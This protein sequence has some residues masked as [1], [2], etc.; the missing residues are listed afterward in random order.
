MKEKVKLK[1]AEIII[2]M[3]SKFA[4]E[5]P[6]DEYEKAESARRLN[7]FFYQGRKGADITINIE[8]VDRLSEAGRAEPVYNVY[9]FM[10]GKENWRLLKKG[11]G[12]VYISVIKEKRQLML[13]NKDF[14]RVSA[15]LLLKKD[16][17]RVWKVEDVVY[18]F[19]QVL[20]IAYLA[21]RGKGIFTHAVGIRDL[22]GKGLLFAGES[23]CGKSATARLW[24]NHTRAMV[25]NDDRVIVRRQ[26]GRFFIH[27][28][29]WHGAFSDYLGSRIES[30]PL[31]KLFFIYHA[32]KNRLERIR[33]EKTFNYLYP[34]T[35]PVFW[36]KD[37]LENV[38]SFGLDLIKQVP[39][40]RLGFVNDRKII[41][42]VR[43]I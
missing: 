14:N 20:L 31:D 27:G 23:G 21:Q 30:A 12:Y 42:F 17:G 36:N 33:P 18:D 9:H 38:V 43:K 32:P 19:L 35:F 13:V 28:S 11:G 3:Q 7:N 39:C 4:L 16:K 15:Y 34:S 41:N 26:N 29:P 5:V 37:Y 40:Y 1:I 24:H 10:D 25:L 8:I 6:A 2:Q 22:N